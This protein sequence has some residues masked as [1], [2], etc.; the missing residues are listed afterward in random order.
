MNVRKLMG[1]CALSAAI[2]TLAVATQATATP[3]VD[4]SQ[5]LSNTGIPWPDDVPN[6]QSFTAGLTGQLT[7]I[8]FFSNGPNSGGTATLKV[9]SGD[10]LGGTALGSINYTFGSTPASSPIA[11]DVSSLNI[12]VTAGS[13]YTFDVAAFSGTQ[14]ILADTSNPYA[15][16]HA[17][18]NPSFYGN[19][20][21]WDLAF[22]TFVNVPEPSTLALATLALGSL[23]LKR[24]L[25]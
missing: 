12:S 3:V 9:Y 24:R 10:G 22:Q 11:F 5:L 4:Q 6:G 19:T 25:S 7:E 15:G 2:V 21:T 18:N 17:Y 13:V 23:W 1:L 14:Q 20:P 16:G 8:D